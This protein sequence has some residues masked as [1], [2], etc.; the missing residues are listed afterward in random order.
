MA[1]CSLTENYQLFGGT[2]SLYFQSLLKM[3]TARSSETLA[4]FYHITLRHTPDDRNLHSH[5]CKTLKSFLTNFERIF[6]ECYL[7][8]DVGQCLGYIASNGR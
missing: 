7:F 1:R 8:N 6:F 4:T 3:E 2:C 5:R